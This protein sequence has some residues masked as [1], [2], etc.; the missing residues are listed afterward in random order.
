MKKKYDN[1]VNICKNFSTPLD[2]LTKFFLDDCYKG[3]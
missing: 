1:N 2:I 3:V